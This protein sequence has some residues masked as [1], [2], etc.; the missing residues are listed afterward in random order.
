M[1]KDDCHTT[2]VLRVCRCTR[3]Q[4]YVGFISNL[5]TF[6]INFLIAFLFK[7]SRPRRKRASRVVAAVRSM[8]SSQVASVDDAVDRPETPCSEQRDTRPMLLS[9]SQQ[10]G[11][12]S[13]AEPMEPALQPPSASNVEFQDVDPW[14]DM[15]TQCDALPSKKKRLSLPWWCRIIAWLLLWTTVGVC[16]AFVT[17][18]GIMFQDDKCKMWISSMIISFLTSVL[19]TQPIKVLLLALFFALLFKKTDEDE[20][21]EELEDEEDHELGPDEAWLHSSTFAGNPLMTK[22]H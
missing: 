12:Q 19:F 21:E 1:V 6:P 10:W 5:I 2:V 16:V 4:L 20:D 13:Y 22:T 11:G 3:V 17:F 8:R 9:D 15:S 18:F 7:R 14:S